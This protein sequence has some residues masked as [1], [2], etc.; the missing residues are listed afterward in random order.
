MDIVCQHVAMVSV[1]KTWLKRHKDILL[2]SMNMKLS[3]RN[4]LKA[5]Y[6]PV[7]VEISPLLLLYKNTCLCYCLL[8]YRVDGHTTLNKWLIMTL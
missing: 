3:S 6:F 1:L 2:T 5:S 4:L 7:D 8:V